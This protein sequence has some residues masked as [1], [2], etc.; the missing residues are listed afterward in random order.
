MGRRRLR[1]AGTVQGVGFRPHLHRLARGLSLTGA[2]GND[3]EGVWCEVQ[4]RRDDLDE[5]EARVAAEAP[6][7]SRVDSVRSADVPRG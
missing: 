6:P 4:G 5:F 7:L 3:D 1:I 2:A